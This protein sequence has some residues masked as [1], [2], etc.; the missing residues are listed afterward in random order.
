MRQS[1]HKQKQESSTECARGFDLSSLVCVYDCAR[2]ARVLNMYRVTSPLHPCFAHGAMSQRDGAEELPPP[3]RSRFSVDKCPR[4]LEGRGRLPDLRQLT[5]EVKSLP[6]PPRVV[7]KLDGSSFFVGID[8]ETHALV[9]RGSN[10]QSFW[11]S[12]EF[13]FLTTA[14]NE[15]LSL[16]RVVQIGWAYA[17]KD[18]DAL[19]I[20]SCLVKPEGFAIES[21][22]TEKHG[23]KHDFAFEHGRP[24]HEVLCEFLDDVLALL[25]KG[26]RICAHHLGFDAGILSREMTRAGIGVARGDWDQRVREGLCTMDPDI[27]HWVRQSIGIGDKPRSIPMRLRDL[28]AVLLPQQVH[29]LARS[30]TAGADAHM[31]M[32]ISQELRRRAMT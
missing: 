7:E 11:K 14:D 31:H 27:C 9:P 3:K 23:I 13:G 10:Q 12:G 5:Q 19:V 29:L 15:A 28:V 20:K 30:H 32:L 18:A 17:T 24:L 8:V 2:L 16:L 25:Q 21:P 26:Y 22:A 6:A 4:P 1:W